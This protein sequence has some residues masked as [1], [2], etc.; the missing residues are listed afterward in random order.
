MSEFI[1]LIFVKRFTTKRKRHIQTY[2]YLYCVCVSAFESAFVYMLIEMTK[3]HKR[4]H[5]E[6]VQNFVI[7]RKIDKQTQNILHN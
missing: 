3:K 7:I 6:F 1:E 5:G 2:G 4:K